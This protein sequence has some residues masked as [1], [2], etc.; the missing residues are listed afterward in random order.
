MSLKK[1]NLNK[2]DFKKFLEYKFVLDSWK[3]LSFG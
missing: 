2:W 3:N 1:K